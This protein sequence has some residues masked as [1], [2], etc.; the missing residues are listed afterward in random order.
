VI[1]LDTNILMYA[2]GRD[3]PLRDGCR[4][5]IEAIGGG[6][7]RATTTVSVIEEFMHAR[8]R[9]DR[10][11]A[12]KIA[13]DFATLLTPL[14][15]VDADDLHAGIRLF[16]R[17]GRLDAFDAVLA[18]TAIRHDADALVSADRAFSAVRGLRY[19]D[20]ATDGLNELLT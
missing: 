11:A 13:T 1:V 7:V 18:A 14:L 6:I 8:G 17:E 20:P 3:H 9:T 12:S 15:V 2:A 4:R 10:A 16:E 5:L 19:I